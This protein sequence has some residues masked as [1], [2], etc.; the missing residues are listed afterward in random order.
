METQELRNQINVSLSLHKVDTADTT[1][2]WIRP[3]RYT[4]PLS[5]QIIR[6]SAVLIRLYPLGQAA[7]Y[8]AE[9][10]TSGE[11]VHVSL[12]ISTES[13]EVSVCAA[14]ASLT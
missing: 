2:P 7:T 4:V 14:A 11:S 9:V 3:A 12:G 5:R 13:T 6:I 8:R 10:I 1:H